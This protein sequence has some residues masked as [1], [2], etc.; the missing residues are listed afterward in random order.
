[1]TEEELPEQD[2]PPAQDPAKQT[3]ADFFKGVD[4]IPEDKSKKNDAE[5]FKGVQE[6]DAATD[7][8]INYA[9]KTGAKI[10]GERAKR[11]LNVRHRLSENTP[12]PFIDRNLD[13]LEQKTSEK[14]FEQNLFYN[15]DTKLKDWVTENAP[16]AALLRSNPEEMQKLGLMKLL[17]ERPPALW[18]RLRSDDHQRSQ[19]RRQA[20]GRGRL[21]EL[22]RRG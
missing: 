22:H 19:D 15:H 8:G 17:I 21:E 1:M 20:P 6:V 13:Y 11:I 4:S 3:D 12:V 7:P 10:D 14:D 18:P 9:I 16:R 2:A 5:F